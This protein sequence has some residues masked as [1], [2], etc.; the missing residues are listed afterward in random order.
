MNPKHEE[1]LDLARKRFMDAASAETVLRANAL[2]DLKFRAGRQWPE[3]VQKQRE[4]D[5]RPC[6]TINRLPAF[7]RQ[8]TNEQRQNRPAIKIS[9]VDGGADP[10]T[11]EVLQGL[12]RHIEISSNA[13]IA[14]DTAFEAAATGG[15]GYFRV[16]TDYCDAD[17]FDQDI[18]IER[19]RN[20]FSVYFDPHTRCPVYS[21]ARYCFVVTTMSREEF[22]ARW[23]DADV[24]E[25]AYAGIGDSSREWLTED[26]VRVAEYFRVEVEQ[27][28]LLLL[29][30]G[31]TVWADEVPAGVQ[32]AVKR[33]RLAERRTIHWAK[34]N[35][36]EVL[37][38]RVWPGRWIPVIPVLGDELDIDGERELVGLI[39]YA[40]DPQRMYNYWASAETEAI[41]LAPRVP[42]V[43]A[44]GQFE[45]HEAKWA[46]ANNRNFPYL[47]YKPKTI[48]GLLAPP[49]QRQ[50]FEP[51]VMAITQARM[52][53]ADDL[54]ATT[55]I[56]DA[57]LGAQGNETSGKAI[58]A[59]QQEGDTAN[60]HLVDNLS[61]SI[62]H[63]GKILVD[64]APKVYDG[65]RVL[66]IIG[67]DD[68]EQAVQ[69]NAPTRHKGVERI[70]DF[71]VGKYDV[72]VATG[73]SYASRRQQAVETLLELV[74]SYPAIAEVAGDL[75]LKNMDFPGA[76]EVSERLKKIL[77]PALQDSPEG[78][79][80][81]PPQAQAQIAQLTQQLEMVMAEL[82][83]A[84]TALE[85]K[86]VE[87]GMKR[88]ELESRERIAAAQ[89][90]ADLVKVQVGIA[91]KEDTTLLMAELSAIR[92]ELNALRASEMQMADAGSP[93]LAAA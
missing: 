55:G 10:E 47:E 43:G 57:S 38:E 87:T 42:F 39:R 61:R 12:I 6:L 36:V 51:A 30:D 26:S 82:Q 66:R 1:L 78:E 15:F 28:K 81:I 67:D 27:K 24:S 3:E 25:I 20:P 54:K 32:L 71:S 29:E 88:L 74:R 65:E 49:P 83:K 14:Y 70:F 44:E 9:P 41:A 45:G 22:A 73:P 91:S 52:Q 90:Q 19:I 85:Q 80:P 89:I 59:R 11:A 46:Q 33:S 7:L 17:S 18:K 62:R 84:S 35:G 79:E 72:V 92:E 53:A 56:H 76:A 31:S 64:L 5:K 58:L 2:D 68:T 8:V 40:K 69:I 23:P 50:A 48:A 13:S 16:L 63:L 75:L 60:Y 21:D 93:E 77:P 37:E 86:Q 34:I 4:L